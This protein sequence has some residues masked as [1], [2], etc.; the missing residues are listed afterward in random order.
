MGAFDFVGGVGLWI[1][2]LRLGCVSVFGW[3]VYYVLFGVVLGLMVVGG[4]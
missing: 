4:F 1:T 3:W 2:W